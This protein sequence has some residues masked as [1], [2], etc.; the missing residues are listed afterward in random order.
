MEEKLNGNYL[1]LRKYAFTQFHAHYTRSWIDLN[2]ASFGCS[3]RYKTVVHNWH[4]HNSHYKTDAFNG[5]I[6]YRL[7]VLSDHV[8]S[9]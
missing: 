4:I 5:N 1:R 7:F 6:G 2:Q 3:G 9:M 8:H